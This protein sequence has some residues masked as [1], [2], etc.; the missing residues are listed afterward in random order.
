MAFINNVAAI[1]AKQN[2]QSLVCRL[3]WR[4]SQGTPASPDNHVDKS[5]QSD[6]AAPASPP[7][8][9]QQPIED[10]ERVQKLKKMHQL[11]FANRKVSPS[12]VAELRYSHHCPNSAIDRSPSLR[13]FI[14][15]PVHPG[16]KLSL[17]NPQCGCSTY[18]QTVMNAPVPSL[19]LVDRPSDLF[20]APN[21]IIIF[22]FKIR[23]PGTPPTS[24]R[25]EDQSPPERAPHTMT[26][27]RRSSFKER[28]A[29]TALTDAIRTGRFVQ[30][31]QHA[32]L[33]PG[34]HQLSTVD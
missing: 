2:N 28:R 3:N 8:P 23:L 17:R 6:S 13:S 10:S 26:N 7:V 19:S 11:K 31:P 1:G 5:K 12:H 33:L 27:K 14:P 16:I 25:T 15:N 9:A 32:I 22:S 29:V 34:H 18:P 30:T 21:K 24:P 20:T 4:M